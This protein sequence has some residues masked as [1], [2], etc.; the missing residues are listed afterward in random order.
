MQAG[1]LAQSARHNCCLRWFILF[2]RQSPERAL[3]GV[4]RDEWSP[5]QE[6]LKASQSMLKRYAIVDDAV[7][8]L[9]VEKLARSGAR[10]R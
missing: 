6:N 3:A 5:R 10:K 9:G 8:K 4:L 1:Y 7:L 2:G